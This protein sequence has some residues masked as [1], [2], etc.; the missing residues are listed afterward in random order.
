MALGVGQPMCRSAQSVPVLLAVR[1]GLCAV[2]SPKSVIRVQSNFVLLPC[3]LFATFAEG[4][5]GYA[6]TKRQT[7]CRQ[8]D[9]RAWKTEERQPNP[10]VGGLMTDLGSAWR[11]AR[12]RPAGSTPVPADVQTCAHPAGTGLPH[13]TAWGQCAGPLCPGAQA[14]PEGR[15]W[16][17]E[18]ALKVGR[19]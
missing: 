18:S 3:R 13:W 10:Q 6:E 8:Q 4:V 7:R 16:C 11:V 12:L 1:R 9:E 19:S 2:C 15:S 14:V 5:A 17:A